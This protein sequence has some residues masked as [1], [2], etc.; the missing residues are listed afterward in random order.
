[1]HRGLNHQ[2]A[3]AAA[4]IRFVVSEIVALKVQYLR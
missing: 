3:N 1:M 2:I 4:D